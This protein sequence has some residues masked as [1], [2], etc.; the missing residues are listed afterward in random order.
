MWID[1]GARVFYGIPGSARGF[2]VADDTPG[3]VFDPSIGQRQATTSGIQTARR[4]LNRRFPAL[5]GAP[6]VSAEVCQYEATPDSHFIIDRHPAARNVWIIGGG[7]GHGYKMG[8]AI[9]EMMSAL[10]LDGAE[11]NPQFGLRRFTKD[12]TQ[13]Q[14]DQKWS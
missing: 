5:R 13:Q 10:L 8:P 11:L 6:L 14:W 4:F 3:P 2:K 9:G 12:W 1:V 7:S